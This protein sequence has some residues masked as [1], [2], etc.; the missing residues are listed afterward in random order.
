M[1]VKVF[2]KKNKQK[3]APLN[4]YCEKITTRFFNIFGGKEVA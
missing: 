1:C 4:A 2:F 3:Q